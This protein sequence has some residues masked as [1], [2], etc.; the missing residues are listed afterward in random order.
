[1]LD[2]STDKSIYVQIAEIIE[3]D[4]LLGNLKEEEQAPSTNQFA[5]IYQINP[6]TAGKGLNI[7]VEEGILYKKRGIGMFVAEGARKKIIKK[8]QSSFFKEILPEIMIEANRLEI[9]TEEIIKFIEEFRG[10]E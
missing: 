2:L 9:T 6:A 5:K 4:I 3:N 7:L 8:R 10:G 1:M